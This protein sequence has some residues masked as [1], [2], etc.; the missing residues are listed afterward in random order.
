VSAETRRDKAQPG[1]RQPLTVPLPTVTPHT[2]AEIRMI[3]RSPGGA[4]RP[5]LSRHAAVTGRVA[6]VGYAVGVGVENMD[7]Q[8]ASRL[9]SP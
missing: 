6:G 2:M 9:G 8:G 1:R 4:A 5:A 7:V 3:V